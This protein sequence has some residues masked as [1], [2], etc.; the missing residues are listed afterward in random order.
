MRRLRWTMRS[1]IAEHRAYLP[2]ARLRYGHMVVG[3]ASELLIDG[4][5]RSACVYA[6]IAF[7][8]AQP[9][10]VRLA[11]L[12][13]SPAHIIDAVARGVP[14]MVTVRQPRDCVLSCLLREPHTEPG[15]LLRSYTRFYRALMPHRHGIVVAPFERV[16]ADMS[17]LVSEVNER[18]GTA[19]GPVPQDAAAVARVFNVI[20]LRASRPPWENE[21]GYMMSGLK[22]PEVI[23]RL[24]AGHVAANGTPVPFEHRVARPSAKREGLK[25]SVAERYETPE[26]AD[27]RRSA[28][29][30]HR[31]F[32]RPQDT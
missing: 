7:Q 6:A 13:H 24:S 31:V 20:E 28:E 21:I 26:L 10:P 9:T 1:R 27:L 15:Q 29:E 19:F 30:A 3:D 11:H 32:V 16:V 25:E 23:D 17:G 5:T 18:F 14:A 12:L 4:F 22:P 2:L 8:L